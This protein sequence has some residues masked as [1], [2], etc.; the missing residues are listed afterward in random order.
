MTIE[1]PKST[2][3]IVFT[4]P[5]SSGKT[6]TA[7]QL[8]KTYRLPLVE[9][10]ARNYLKEHGPSYKFN[11]LQSIAIGQITNEVKSNANHPMSLCD[12]DLITIEIWALEKFGRSLNLIDDLIHKKHYLLCNPDI[13]WKP[14]PLRENPHDR[15]RL[16]ERYKKYLDSIQTPYTILT[17]EDRAN[18]IIQF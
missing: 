17:K 4:G 15:I 5:E 12:T 6:T 2:E 8:A 7:Q 10:F 14:D 13:P 3:I 18:L 11:D 16:F 9:E 1:L